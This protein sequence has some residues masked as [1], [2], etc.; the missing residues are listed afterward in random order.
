MRAEAVS[1]PFIT[2]GAPLSDTACQALLRLG[3]NPPTYVLSDGAAEPPE[4]SCNFYLDAGTPVPHARLAALAVTTLRRIYRVRHPGE[5]EYRAF[6]D[7]HT[8]IRFP[9]L[10]LRRE[11]R[12]SAGSGSD[13]SAGQKEGLV[14]TQGVPGAPS[15]ELPDGQP[16]AP[17]KV[18]ANLRARLAQCEEALE[19]AV[20]QL[21]R[22]YSM[23]GRQRE[24]R[25]YVNRLVAWTANSAKVA[26]G[27]LARGQLLEQ[28]KRFAEAEVEYAK[29]L[30]IIPP[31]GEVG[32]FLHNN[33]GYCLNTLGRHLEAE[34]HCRAALAIAPTR[35]NAHKNLGLA[36]AGQGRF[37][38]AAHSLLEADRRCPADGRARRHL[39]DLLSA[40]PEL[41]TDSEVAVACEALRLLGET[42]RVGSA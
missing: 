18:E 40:H 26:G 25:V 7:G 42:G 12:A 21:A 37:V 6:A 3:W 34:A 29:G 2:T 8:S 4:G 24:A 31:C 28:E 5:L 22:F 33:R 19:D 10:T 20:W 14:G 38:E 15:F 30:E 13:T 41:L 16:I 27:Y 23:V 17:T 1:N 11:P 32:Y 9:L 35:F 39:F 36:L